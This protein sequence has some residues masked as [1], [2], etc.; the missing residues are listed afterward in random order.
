M[1]ADALSDEANSAAADL[2]IE[3]R[4]VV[5]VEPDGTVL[6]EHAVLVRAGRI[7]AILLLGPILD[8]HYAAVKAA[9]VKLGG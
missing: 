9:T 5:P 7:A 4:W 2:A 6:D 3:A 1:H 8:E